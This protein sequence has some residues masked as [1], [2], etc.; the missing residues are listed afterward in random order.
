MRLLLA[1]DRALAYSVRGLLPLPPR[2]PHPMHSPDPALDALF[3]P[4]AT[5]HLQWPTQGDVLFVGARMGS[6][7]L[8]QYRSQLV[9]E[10][11]YKPDVDA[12]QQADIRVGSDPQSRFPVVLL[13]PPR[14]REHARACYARALE[15]LLPGG[16]LVLSQ[17]NSEG[18]R[19]CEADLRQLAPGAQVLSKHQCRVV[20]AQADASLNLDQL[21]SWRN[22]DAPR[23]IDDGRYWS[24][25]GVFAWDRVDAASQLLAEHLPLEMQGSVADLGGGW[26]F[27]S[28]QVLQRCPQ[29]SALDLYEA[30][31]RALELARRN[32]EPWVDR[33]A[34]GLHWHDVASGLPQRYQNIVSN[35]PFHAQQSRQRVD[36]GKTFLKVAADALLPG[37][38]LWLV[39]NR[40]LPYEAVLAQ[41]FDSCQTLAQS[42]GYK[43]IA[44]RRAEA[45][46][47]RQRGREGGT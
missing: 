4:F 34:L 17:A 37:G 23:Q 31:T 6:A 25:P 33:V 11:D 15:R 9:C 47:A 41:H 12:L 8:Q 13:L 39:A 20:W 18:A 2:Y 19:S 35:P 1:L 43:V 30:D 24:R 27:L 14:Q 29:V 36:L 45:A 5:G 40:H 42:G 7:L 38:R 22:L 26:G 21:G 44:A 28:A 46:P 10:Q 32:L 3:H 16:T